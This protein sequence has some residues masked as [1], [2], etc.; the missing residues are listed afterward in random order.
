MKAKPWWKLSKK[1]KLVNTHTHPCISIFMSSL[2]TSLPLTIP[3]TPTPHPHF[4]TVFGVA[5]ISHLAT[6]F[7]FFLIPGKTSSYYTNVFVYMSCNTLNWG[8]RDRYAPG[9]ESSSASLTR[10]Q[11]WGGGVYF[12]FFI[13]LTHLFSNLF[14]STCSLMLGGVWSAAA[15]AVFSVSFPCDLILC[16]NN[17]TSDFDFTKSATTNQLATYFHL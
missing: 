10:L 3:T 15:W 17:C 9:C 1:K 2:V 14:P 11:G 7:F 5:T 6:S 16:G 8:L 12:L 13:F 4:G